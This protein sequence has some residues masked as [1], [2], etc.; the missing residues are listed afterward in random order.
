MRTTKKLEVR[1]KYCGGCNPYFKRESI[2]EFLRTRY[3]FINFSFESGIFT[4]A[5]NGCTKSCVSGEVI[6]NSMESE[7]QICKKFELLLEKY[8]AKI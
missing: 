5:I 1:I 4:V 3:K 7:E 2:E 8:F 6:F